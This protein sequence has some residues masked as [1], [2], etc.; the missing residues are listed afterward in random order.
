MSKTA[1]QRISSETGRTNIARFT[2]LTSGSFTIGQPAGRVTHY[3][4]CKSRPCV[5]SMAAMHRK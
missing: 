5:N 1:E 3:V 2:T 4:G